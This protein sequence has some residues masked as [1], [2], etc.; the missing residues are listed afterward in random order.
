M[1]KKGTTDPTNLIQSQAVEEALCY[2]WIDSQGKSGGEKIVYQRFTP[3]TAKSIWSQ[4]NIDN[5]ARLD[6]EGRMTS[7]GWDE[8]EKAK[9]DGRGERAY[10]GPATIEAPKDFLEAVAKIPGAQAMWENLT[11]QN[12]F[13][14]CF[15]LL[16]LK[17]DTGRQKRIAA[18]VDMLAGGQTIYPQKE[19]RKV[20]NVTITTTTKD[21]KGPAKRKE[22]ASVPARVEGT[23]KSARIRG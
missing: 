11:S 19:N 21:S 16:N 1:A 13:A 8:V 6:S 17:T 3:R 9:A 12:R 22:T 2:G 4:R 15:R 18:Y 10:A 14:M 5:V 7:R 23:R 20:K